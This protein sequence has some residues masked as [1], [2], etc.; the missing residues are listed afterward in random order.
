MTFVNVHGRTERARL[1]AACLAPLVVLSCGTS[2]GLDL[3][4]CAEAGQPG[5]DGLRLSLTPGVICKLVAADAEAIEIAASETAAQYL[6]VVQ[7]GSRSPSSTVSLRLEATAGG[8]TPGRVATLA[9]PSRRTIHPGLIAEEETSRAELRFRANA[10][11][12]LANARPLRMPRPGALPSDS[13]A[14]TVSA[15]M[16]FALGDTIVFQ[17]AVDS[18]L[19]VDCDGISEITTVVRAMG[20]DIGI[21]EDLE[22]AGRVS[23][24]SYS[25]VLATLED[26]VFPVDT[27]Y[28]GAPA[29]LDGNGIVWV[30]FTAVVNRATP[31]GSSTRVAGFFNPS[32]LSD[33]ATCPAS[34]QG[35]ILYVLA[36]DPGGR[37]SDPVPVSFATSRAVGVGA[38]ELE[39]LISAEQRVVLGGGTFAD[40]EDPW[41]GEGLA[42]SAETAV[43]LRVAGLQPG[44]N[45]GFMGLTADPAAFDA[46]HFA[47]FRRA[48]FYLADTNGTFALGDDVGED[49][50]GISSLEMRGFGW[51]LLRWLADQYAQPSGGLLGGPEEEAI[52]RDLAS[53]GVGRA[54]GIA[55]VERA[56][57]AVGGPGDW[58]AILAGYALS[59]LADDHPGET[60]AS[61]Q[62]TSFQLRD[63]FAGLNVEMDDEEPFKTPFPLL[64]TDIGLNEAT[65][66]VV[67]FD[68]R[69][70]TGRYFVLESTT[71]HPAVRLALTT[72]SGGAVP[73][74]ARVQLVV[75]RTR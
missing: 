64:Q 17:N 6:V 37:F 72:G 10:R 45:H 11:A 52:F 23:T 58:D 61:T 46:Y 73:G 24:A 9:T 28:F 70:S 43:G 29:D 21:V 56:A 54:R 25:N 35:E 59:P 53:G 50:G 41:L 66:I 1:A 30:L 12:A 38:H 40:L 69:A 13:R 36:A 57:A 26:F 68:L 49:P 27:T 47:N 5:V 33:A 63:A 3:S 8:A 55:N 4:A 15:R 48:G 20:D 67:N 65:N 44:Q 62:V 71:S 18:D 31:R 16:S 42:H 39:H 75:L 51:L 34:N 74:S 7:S 19:G 60:D 32:D 2:T 22:V 14:S